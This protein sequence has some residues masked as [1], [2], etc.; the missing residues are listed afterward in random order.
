MMREPILASFVLVC[1]MSAALTLASPA[2]GSVDVALSLDDVARASSLVAR[3]VPLEQSST[4]EG[5][6]I[7]TTTRLRVERVIAGEGA[8]PAELYVRTL[9]GI[10]GQVGQSVEGEARFAKGI[11]SIVFF[12]RPNGESAYAV[13]GRAQGQLV[14][15]RTEAGREVVRVAAV[16]RLVPRAFR[17]PLAAQSASALVTTLDGHDAD[18]ATRD[19]ARAWERT[20][21]R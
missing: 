15:A 1:T 18:E 11:P 16:G 9:G 21:A 10:V 4:W 7:V 20:H 6:R 19:A 3:V 8:T 14:V 12:A 17:V 5:G 2:E 13:A